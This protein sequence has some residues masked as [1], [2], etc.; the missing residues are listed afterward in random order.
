MEKDKQ[1]I[2]PAPMPEDPVN[3]RL[4]KLLVPAPH[5]VPEK[6]AKEKATGTRKSSRCLAVSDS[7]D[8]PDAPSASEDKEEEE[9]EEASPL[10]RGEERK[11][12]PPQLGRPEGPRRGRPLCRTTPPMPKT[13][14][15]NGH[16]GSGPWQ[17]RKCPVTRMTC[18]ATLLFDSF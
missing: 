2:S 9:E 4:A 5:V 1:L 6:K 16:P 13:T 10:Q 3:A 14:G 17:N 7:P 8:N 18:G 12:S 11:E 15:S